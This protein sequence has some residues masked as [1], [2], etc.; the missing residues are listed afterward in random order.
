MQRF[1]MKPAKRKPL[2]NPPPLRSKHVCSLPSFTFLG[3]L[4]F[5][6]ERLLQTVRIKVCSAAGVQ[7]PNGGGSTSNIPVGTDLHQRGLDYSPAAL[8]MWAA[9]DLLDLERWSLTWLNKRKKKEV[10]LCFFMLHIVE[11]VARSKVLWQ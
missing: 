5:C 7:C 4:L 9:A 10:T 8:R 6:E 1:C 11:K 3:L 2:S